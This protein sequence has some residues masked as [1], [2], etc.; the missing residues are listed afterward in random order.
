MVMVN[1]RI[2]Y[3]VSR[4]VEKPLVAAEERNG[5]QEGNAGRRKSPVQVSCMLY[6]RHHVQGGNL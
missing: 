4:L 2:V 5:W 3:I 6:D 1:E